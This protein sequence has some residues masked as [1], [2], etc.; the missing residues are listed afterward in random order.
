MTMFNI[1]FYSKNP[2]NELSK[3]SFIFYLLL[4]IVLFPL[5]CFLTNIYTS[6]VVTIILLAAGIIEL[7][8]AK[9]MIGLDEDKCLKAYK[10]GKLF[11]TISKIITI[12]IIFIL[13]ICNK[14]IYEF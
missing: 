8:I 2:E 6:F 7:S 10:N 1:L 12:V 4:I 3:R 11:N 14:T 5:L 9:N 13:Y